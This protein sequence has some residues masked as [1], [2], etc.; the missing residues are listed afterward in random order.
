MNAQG[1]RF[2]FHVCSGG[3]YP[4]FLFVIL[5]ADLIVAVLSDLSKFSHRF[6][7]HQLHCIAVIIEPYQS[8]CNSR[9]VL[10]VDVV[11]N[12]VTLFAGDI[13]TVYRHS[14]LG[15]YIHKSNTSAVYSYSTMYY[16]IRIYGN[17]LDIRKIGL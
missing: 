10:E 12:S 8:T 4:S 14:R 7:R 17:T 3:Y 9:I 1:K 15:G 16:R 11:I 6:Q 5:S 13:V 2:V